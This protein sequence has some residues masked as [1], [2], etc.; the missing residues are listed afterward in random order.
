MEHNQPYPVG[1]HQWYGTFIIKYDEEQIIIKTGH[2]ARL[3][4][5]KVELFDGKNKPVVLIPGHDFS[6]MVGKYLN[7]TFCSFS[8]PS[9]TEGIKKRT[10]KKKPRAG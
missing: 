2:V 1:T 6:I 5:G 9:A 3:P 10:C 7:E 8:S 4:N